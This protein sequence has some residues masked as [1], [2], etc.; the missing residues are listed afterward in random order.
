MSRAEASVLAAN[1][2]LE[3]TRQ[4]F[5]L[6]G[7]GWGQTYAN[8]Y[9]GYDKILQAPLWLRQQILQRIEHDVS[10]ANDLTLVVG[11]IE[12]T[13]A[14]LTTR[15]TQEQTALSQLSGKPVGSNAL[16]REPSGPL[17]LA[18]ALKRMVE[19]A[20]LGSPTVARLLANVQIQEADMLTRKAALTP[21]EY[22]SA[23]RQQGIFSQNNLPAHNR[24]F[25]GLSNNFRA[26]LSSWSE[27]SGTQ[28]RLASAQVD[29]E[30]ARVALG[31]QIWGE[32]LAAVAR[33]LQF[34]VG[35]KSFGST[36]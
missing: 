23:K 8:W 19:Q 3:V 16:V 26:G 21:E 31:E 2:G 24:V 4:D 25:I 11:R 33:G 29:V 1:T 36:S 9:S 20:Q 28:V 12:Q 32:A 10:A 6:R 34:L 15:Q 35:Q 7:G 30:S 14:E 27:V 18:Q 5:A 17:L 13:Q 22:L